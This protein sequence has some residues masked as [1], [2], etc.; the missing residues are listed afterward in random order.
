MVFRREGQEIG[1]YTREVRGKLWILLLGF[2]VFSTVILEIYYYS[3]GVRRSC[4]KLLIHALKHIRGCLSGIVQT[5]VTVCNCT[6][7][8]P[9][10]TFRCSCSRH[11]GVL[12]VPC[13]RHLGSRCSASSSFRA[14]LSVAHC[15][16]QFLVYEISRALGN[17][18][19]IIR[20]GEEC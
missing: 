20:Q 19:R 2:R 14:R 10:R 11:A 4:D 17:L 1:G 5:I 15:L 12:S 18:R 6:T 9:L 3:N 16:I 7:A 8:W 13:R